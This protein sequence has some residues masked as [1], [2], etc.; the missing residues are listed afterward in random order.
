MLPHFLLFGDFKEELYWQEIT[1]HYSLGCLSSSLI[2]LFAII[3]LSNRWSSHKDHKNLHS[4]RSSSK[5]MLSTKCFI[6]E[7]LFL[8]WMGSSRFQFWWMGS[9]RFQWPISYLYETQYLPKVVYAVVFILFMRD[10]LGVFARYNFFAIIFWLLKQDVSW[11]STVPQFKFGF[12]GRK[13]LIFFIHPLLFLHF[14][15]SLLIITKTL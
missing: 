6:F 5:S 4:I 11:E 2:S 10:L 3:W 15:N 12:V 7:M 9:S 14:I 1:F 13:L 8:W